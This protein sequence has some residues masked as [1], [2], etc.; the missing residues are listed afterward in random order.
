MNYNKQQST[1]N[2]NQQSTMN[3]NKQQKYYE[4]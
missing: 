1:M 3:Y 2:Y 4:L